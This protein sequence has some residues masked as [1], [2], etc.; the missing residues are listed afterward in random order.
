M[1]VGRDIRRNA[2]KICAA[3]R[4][5]ARAGAEI[6]L[7]PEGALSG[8][9]PDFDVRRQQEALDQV[10]TLARRHSVGLA[11]GTCAVEA[12]GKCYNQLRFYRPTGEYLGFHSKTLLCGSLDPEPQGEI[13]HY[14]V[15]P[16]RVFEWAPGLLI[17]GLI[18]NDVWANPQ[19]TPMPDAHL[20]QRLAEMGARVIFHAVNGGRDGSEA[21]RLNWQFHDANLRM[22]AQAG[23]V[24][25]V[26]VDNAGPARWPCSSPSGIVDNA[27]AWACAA[28][29][30]GPQFFAHTIDLTRGGKR[31]RARC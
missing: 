4:Q 15:A 23:D 10:T 9:R 8:Y 27:G 16:L 5:A 24:H 26:T 20:T 1:A 14:A 29:P 17:G 22:R 6:L 11:L 31:R 30:L 2:A 18:C 3:I 28:N 13:N 25:I 7:T 19:C 21:S 12:D